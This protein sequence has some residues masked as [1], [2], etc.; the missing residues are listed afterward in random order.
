M[1]L[2][3]GPDPRLKYATSGIKDRRGELWMLRAELRCQT[4]RDDRDGRAAGDARGNDA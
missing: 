1:P 4:F 3:V 2:Y